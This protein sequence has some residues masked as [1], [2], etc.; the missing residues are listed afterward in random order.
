[1][2]EKITVALGCDHGGYEVK[3]MIRDYL[4]AKGFS[5]QDF[6]CHSTESCDYPVF[7]K[8]AAQAVGEGKCRFGV[9]VC[10]TGIGVS[11]CAN[12]VKGVR[13]ALCHDS[14]SAQM[15]RRHNDAN[16]LALGA[17]ITGPKLICEILDV[18]FSTEFEG[19][20]HQRRVDEMMAIEQG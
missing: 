14:F 7:A 18:F 20:R 6:G 12:K 9:V 8:A 19:G 3:E 4:T 2:E 17:G 1:M 13:C 15:T 11:I 5:C 10:T 16:M